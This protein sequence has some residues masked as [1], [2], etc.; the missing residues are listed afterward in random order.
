[1][2]A[3]RYP[4]RLL[5]E[6]IILSVVLPA[7]AGAVNASGF[8]EVGIYSS[9][10]TGHVAKVGETLVAGRL[11]DTAG[12]VML[13]GAFLGGATLATL[14]IGRARRRGGPRYAAALLVQ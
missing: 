12:E 3:S 4:R 1:M 2:P 13:L 10:M 11:H 5:L 8:Q 14:L 9:H 7:L 6:S